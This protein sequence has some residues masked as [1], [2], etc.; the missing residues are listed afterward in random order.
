MALIVTGQR[1]EIAQAT[2][3][4]LYLRTPTELTAGTGVLSISI[5]GNVTQ[6]AVQLSGD[7]QPGSLAVPFQR[8]V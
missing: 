4:H 5:D 8:I 1:F 3:T 7:I 2:P 6:Q